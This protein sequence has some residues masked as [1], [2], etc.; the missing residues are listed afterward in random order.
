VSPSLGLAELGE[1]Y[2]LSDE[3]VER[4]ALLAE[5]LVRDPGA[6]TAVRDPG[7]VIE[8]HLA[9]ALVALELPSVPAAAAIADLGSGAGVPGL[10][11]AIALP[12]AHV[13]LV[14]SARR[15][16]AFI[17]RAI[18]TCGL[19]NADVVNARAESWSAGIGHNDIVT[20]R[21]LAPLVVVAE[22]AAPLLR[23][24][25][26]LVVWRG[27]RQADEEAATAR[28]AVELGLEPSA[29]LPVQPYP[30]VRNRHLH[31]MTKVA[32]TPARFPRR[33]GAARKRPLS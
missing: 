20:A 23:L 31:V 17:S 7:R 13:S 12:D 6:A 10:P 32:P 3:A 11:L 18:S 9:D 30:G 1:R 4:L 27:Q 21:A 15:K 5:L 22:Y 26:E 33:P 19:A 16:C 8:D 2:A 24:G 25:G 14:E 28:A 29:P